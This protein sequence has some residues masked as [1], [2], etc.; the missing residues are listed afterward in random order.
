MH[1]SSLTVLQ[2]I[3]GESED[4]QEF[5]EVNVAALEFAEVD[6][7]ALVNCVFV[8]CILEKV[9]YIWIIINFL[10]FHFYFYKYAC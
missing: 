3:I 9:H 4:T 2:L 1:N 5:G 6:V 8:I 7:A 10:S